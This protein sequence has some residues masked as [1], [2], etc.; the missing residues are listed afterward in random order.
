MGADKAF[1]EVGGRPMIV[2]V[3]DALW[4][5]GCHRV[6]CQGGSPEL[7]S[8]FGFEVVPD[9]E[10]GGGPVP[11]ILAALEHH[12]GPILV[13]ACDLADLDAASVRIVVEAGRTD[14]A[15]SV[16]VAAVD[17]RP[18]LLSLWNPQALGPLR[19][20]VDEGVSAYSVALDRLAARPVEVA[21]AAVRNVNRPQ[22]LG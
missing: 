6:V 7:T 11:A 4:G 5:A 20:L 8:S 16:A 9:P 13:A 19:A 12:G 15:P 3:A 10:P 14:P 1:V 22:D 17:G 18:Q 21:A 2:A